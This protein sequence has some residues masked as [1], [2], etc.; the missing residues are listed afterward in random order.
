MAAVALTAD[1]AEPRNGDSATV[2]PVHDW[3]FARTA[4]GVTAEV[5]GA[6]WQA[7]ARPALFRLPLKYVAANPPPHESTVHPVPIRYPTRTISLA[8][9]RV[10]VAGPD[11]V[12]PVALAVPGAESA[13]TGAIPRTPCT[14]TPPP[15]APVRLIVSTLTRQGSGRRTHDPL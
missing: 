13:A 12:L 14:T 7:S 9:V 11:G 10:P 15:V 5:D 2:K 4:A 3:L 6:V 1:G 8:W